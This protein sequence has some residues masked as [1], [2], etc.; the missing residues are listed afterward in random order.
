MD[1]LRRNPDEEG[2][3][4]IDV[5]MQ[6]SVSDLPT[7]HGAWIQNLDYPRT[8][9]SI[10]RFRDGVAEDNPTGN[11][12][13]AEAA[14]S[15]LQAEYDAEISASSYKGI[16][17]DLRPVELQQ[18]E[19]MADFN[20]IEEIGSE[21]IVTPHHGRAALPTRDDAKKVALDS[22]RRIIDERY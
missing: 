3:L 12:S 21:T 11:Y 5:V 10:L 9:W 6:Y 4:T 13:S 15:A 17:I 1:G 2:A 20:L 16:G 19:W 14:L 22:A 8:L 18:G 7:G